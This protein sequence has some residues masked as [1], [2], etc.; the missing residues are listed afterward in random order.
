MTKENEFLVSVSEVKFF[1]PQTNDLILNGKTKLDTSMQQQVQSQVINAGKGSKGIYEYNYQKELTFTVTEATFDLKYL[2]MQNGTGILRELGDYFADE[3]ITLDSTGKGTLPNTPFGTVHVQADNG[4]YVQVVPNGNEFTYSALA[5]K[6]VN[7]V[8][9]Y[10]EVMDTIKITGD[11]FPKAVTMVMNADINTH[12]GKVGEMQIIVPQYKPNGALELSMTAGGVSSTPMTGR[13]LADQKGV[14][15]IVSV[16]RFDNDIVQVHSLY[17]DKPELTLEAGLTPADSEQVT[18][19]GQRGGL[20]GTIQLDNS[21][22][23][24][25]SD[26]ATIAAVD[27]NGVITLAASANTGDVVMVRVADAAGNRDTVEVT[28]I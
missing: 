20:Y 16:K 27:T 18:V 8:Y 22:L 13:A 25:T 26:N 9:A 3:F 12:N 5:N 28:V 4:E 15:A 2:A 11:A 19:Y 23:T 1:D 17:V 6:E 14:Y 21:D 24:F 10:K 7:V